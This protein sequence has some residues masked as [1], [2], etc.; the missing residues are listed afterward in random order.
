MNPDGYHY[1]RTVDRLW[2]KNRA[3]VDG[4]CY[5]VDL[6]R[7]H[8]YNWAKRKGASTDPCS[9]VY[10]GVMVGDQLETIAKRDFLA[11]KW[12]QIQMYLSI[13]SAADAI[14]VPPGD[15]DDEI[16]ND[17][18]FKF[19][20]RLKRA[21]GQN[22]V[23]S[24]RYK[25]FKVQ[26]DIVDASDLGETTGTGDDWALKMNVTFAFTVELP[27][28]EILPGETSI[29]VVPEPLL[30]PILSKYIKVSNLLPLL[31][32]IASY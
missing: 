3:H 17:D 26:P 24:G 4:A 6:N 12:N 29:F 7:N 18:L 19:A 11:D 10:A 2:R 21:I 23:T 8:D 14:F 30:L 16:N 20:S 15:L 1:S 25:G 22:R 31:L 5:G 27:P 28:K 13:H 9:D 32:T